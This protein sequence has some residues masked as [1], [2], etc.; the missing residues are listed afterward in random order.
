[1]RDAGA[2]GRGC[3]AIDVDSDT[4]VAATPA[5]KRV[6]V[7][8][9]KSNSGKVEQR[10]ATARSPP[11]AT[12]DN[13]LLPN[14]ILKPVEGY[15]QEATERA[16]ISLLEEGPKWVADRERSRVERELV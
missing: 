1:M 13:D 4:F 11:A 2:V 12:W 8:L 7:E 5:K 14:T 15:L 6:K 9:G 10:A 3:T 16:A